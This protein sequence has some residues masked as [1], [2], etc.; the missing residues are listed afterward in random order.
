MP[1][2]HVERSAG[3]AGIAF[4]LISVVGLFLNGIPPLITWPAGDVGDF[5]FVHRTL[6]LVGAWLTLPESAFFFWFVVQLRSFLRATADLDDGLPT[7]MLVAGMAAGILAL[8]TGMLQGS[9]GFRP[10]DISLIGVR[11]LF[12]TYTMASTFIFIPL[13]VMVFATSLSARRHGTLPPWLVTLGYAAAAGATIKSLSLF[14]TGGFMA[15]GGIGTM[16]I[17]VVP[18]MVWMAAVA[19]ELI[20]SPR[21]SV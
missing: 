14:F 18:L 8:A 17:G 12:D 19:L 2:V 10:Q 5:V 21:K 9:L 20:R 13:I 1:N 15:L 6:W 3:Y 11:V 16:I 7:Y 4:V